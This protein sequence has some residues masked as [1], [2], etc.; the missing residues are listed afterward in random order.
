MTIAPWWTRLVL[1]AALMWPVAAS[2]SATLDFAGKVS[3]GGLGEVFWYDELRADYVSFDDEPVT[4]SLTIDGPPS[5]PFVSSF[6][7]RWSD[8]TYAIPVTTEW[9]DSGYPA[10]FQGAGFIST[11]S[12]GPAGGDIRIFP[13]TAYQ[14]LY[15]GYFVL[16]LA[17]GNGQPV[18]NGRIISSVNFAFDPVRGPYD[19]STSLNF[20]LTS[21]RVT[22]VPE[23][24]AWLLLLS[25]FAG[26]GVAVRR[27]RAAGTPRR[28]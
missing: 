19:T 18:G 15:D 7:A 25:G 16:E 6:S 20:T 24:G 14:A 23:P 4:I 11:V 17:Y 12:L 1:A 22:S 26:L 21:V 2:A 3:P 8:D 9:S 27:A 13:T 28:R 5:Q 10:E